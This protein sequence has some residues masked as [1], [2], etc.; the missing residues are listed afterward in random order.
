MKPPGLL[1]W[2]SGSVRMDMDFGIPKEL[3]AS[4]P[5]QRLRA[6]NPW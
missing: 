5:I 3:F 1:S 4:S 6:W 2:P